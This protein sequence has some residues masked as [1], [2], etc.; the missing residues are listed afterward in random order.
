MR[1]TALFS[2]R[3]RKPLGPSFRPTLETLEDRWLPSLLVVSNLHDAGRGSLRRAIAQANRTAAAD[4][5][6]FAPG[7]T[8]TIR[9]AASH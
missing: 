3:R 7:L 4:T 8:G 9:L 1:F 5:I 6:E 2:N